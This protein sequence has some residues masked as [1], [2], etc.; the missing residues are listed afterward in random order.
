MGTR[1]LRS[2]L[3]FCLVLTDREGLSGTYRALRALKALNVHDGGLGK[4][5][6]SN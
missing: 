1:L 2:V 4:P 6:D 5:S 3:G